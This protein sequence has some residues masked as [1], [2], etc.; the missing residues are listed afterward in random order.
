MVVYGHRFMGK[1]DYD[2]SF[3]YDYPPLTMKQVKMTV[4]CCIT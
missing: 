3:Y 2:T 4:S 1:D